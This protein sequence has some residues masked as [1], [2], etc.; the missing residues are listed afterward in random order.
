MTKEARL[1][2]RILRISLALLLAHAAIA[3]GSREERA[4]SA[5]PPATTV[6]EATT[7]PATG[8][9]RDGDLEWRLQASSERLAMSERAAWRLRMVAVNRGSTTASPIETG[10]S[11]FAVNGEPSMV[12]SLAFGNGALEPGWTSLPPGES[13]ST[14]RE[15][16]ESLF[17]APGTYRID[18]THG[19]ATS[20]VTIAVVP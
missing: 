3:C 1:P 19:T 10:P 9:A 14:E 6:S 8:S 17:D 18:L 20:S 7:E 2:A 4:P 12:A 16:G 5:P 13:V 11:S 15:L